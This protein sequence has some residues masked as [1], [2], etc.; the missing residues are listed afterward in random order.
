MSEMKVKVAIDIESARTHAQSVMRNRYPLNDLRELDVGA[1]GFA[2]VNIISHK[3][4][5]PAKG[6]RKLGKAL[7]AA[8][9]CQDYRRV[10]YVWN[11]ASMPVQ[12]VDILEEG[13]RVFA[14]ALSEMGYTCA[15]CS[16]LD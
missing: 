4:Y 16:R 15:I 11:P 13:A 2:W 10:Y 7:T 3:T 6:N 1:C 8:G 9:V 5:G 12:S 14:G